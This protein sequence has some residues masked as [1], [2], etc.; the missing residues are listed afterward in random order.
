MADVYFCCLNFYYV[1]TTINRKLCKNCNGEE[2]DKIVTLRKQDVVKRDHY[3][4]LFADIEKVYCE[5]CNECC[6]VLRDPSCCTRCTAMMRN[7]NKNPDENSNFI[8]KIQ[9][10]KINKT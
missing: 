4:K 1:N 6:T 10:E 9:R 7:L 2:I 5:I 3:L 8:Q